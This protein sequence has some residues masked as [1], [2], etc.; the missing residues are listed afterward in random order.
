MTN[1][2]SR[3]RK[4]SYGI[5]IILLLGPIVYLG[6]SCGA[7][8]LRIP[9]QGVSASSRRCDSSMTWAKP[10]WEKWIRPALR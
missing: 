8:L 5:G 4:M 1:L 10:L 7:E 6:I 2:N 3:Q 9:P